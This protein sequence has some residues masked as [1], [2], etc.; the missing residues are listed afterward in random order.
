[1]GPLHITRE[2]RTYFTLQG[3]YKGALFGVIHYEF[4]TPHDQL[5]HN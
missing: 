3:E 1:M 5:G 2:N 4:S